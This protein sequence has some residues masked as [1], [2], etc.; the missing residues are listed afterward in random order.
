MQTPGNREITTPLTSLDALQDS[1][2][3]K[4]NTLELGTIAKS[5]RK[6]SFCAWEKVYQKSSLTL[7]DALQDLNYMSIHTKRQWQ[8]STCIGRCKEES[9]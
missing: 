2:D 3:K 5:E 4:L 7:L 9:I 1:K 8:S 6:Q